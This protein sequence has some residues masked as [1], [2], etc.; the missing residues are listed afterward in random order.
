MSE[1]IVQADRYCF[2]CGPDNPIGL[3]LDFELDASGILRSRFVPRRELQGYRFQVH[4]GIVAVFLDELMVRL[5]YMIGIPA[6]SAEMTVRY[7]K[8]IRVGVEV[9]GF[10]RILSSRGR[11]FELESEARS[12]GGGEL[13]A[14][15]RA[16]ALRVRE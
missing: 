3:R 11:L 1:L 9:E 4:G 2:A 5:L 10:G 13:L 7:L 16:R 15:A 8:P 12:A 6:V 14:T